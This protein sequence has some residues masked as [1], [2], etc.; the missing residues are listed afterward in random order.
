MGGN[1]LSVTSTRLTKANY[2]RMAQDCVTKL[3]E[4][5][6]Q[7]RVVAI[8][9]YESKTDHGDLDLLVSFENYD[10]YAAAKALA[11]TEVVRNGPVTSLGVRVR[12]EVEELDGNVFQVDLISIDAASFDYAAAYFSFNDLG[13]L[14]GRTAH[15]AG[16]AHKH[17]GLWFYVRDGDYHFREILLTRNYDEAL[18]FLG[19]SPARFHAGFDSLSDIFEYVAGSAYFNRNIFLLE[20]R[21]AQSR[22]RDRK[23]KT[24]TEFLKFCEAH[25]ELPGYAYP[26][27]KADWLPRIEQGFPA[28]KAEH[29]KALADLAELR[30]V[31]AKFNGEWVS[32]LTGLQGKEL[33]ELMK[34]FKASFE[35]IEAQRT[36]VLTKTPAELEL[37]VRLELSK[38][39]GD[40]LFPLWEMLEAGVPALPV[41]AQVARHLAGLQA[42]PTN[43]EG[44]QAAVQASREMLS[45][46]DETP[47]TSAAPLTPRSRNPKMDALVSAIAKANAFSFEKASEAVGLAM[48]ERR[49]DER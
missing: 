28:F 12:P 4:T 30:A 34:R 43:T 10:P 48:K 32:Q 40:G 14:I 44:V 37:R 46:L 1:A 35:S 41:R 38:L 31:K 9:S 13:N 20:N 8:A 3:K 26:E 45:Y 47:G 42:L 6:P 19:Y 17:N 36:F 22:I 24:Y 21:N 16:L 49:D 23:R 39:K 27:R 7:G 18:T 15:A 11:A 25:P 33:G 29:D 2:E 5:F